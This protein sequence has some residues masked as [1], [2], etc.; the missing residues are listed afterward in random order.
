MLE[1]A[2]NFALR[3]LYPASLFFLTFCGSKKEHKIPYEQMPITFND[4]AT[5]EVRAWHSTFSQ[6]YHPYHLNQMVDEIMQDELGSAKKDGVGPAVVDANMNLAVD[7]SN[8]SPTF[9]RPLLKKLKRQDL[10]SFKES[11]ERFII[12][13]LQEPSAAIKYQRTA[14][15][16]FTTPHQDN[17]R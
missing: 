13:D 9:A 4:T 16:L 10:L 5:P 8:D 7:S 11:L 14:K 12:D 15:S 17:Q 6:S 2:Q 3:Y 1:R